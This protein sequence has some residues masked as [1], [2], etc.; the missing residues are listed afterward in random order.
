L[1]PLVVNIKKLWLLLFISLVNT[2]CVTIP[3]VE[4]CSVAGSM[5]A[6]SDCDQTL[7]SSPKRIS[8]EETVAVLEGGGVFMTADAFGQMK[9]A[10][11]EACRELGKRCKKE[12]KQEPR[13]GSNVRLESLLKIAEDIGE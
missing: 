12:I 3:N 2:G 6:G 1:R 4:V 7:V 9:T 13:R 10:L 8:L 11:E 5:T